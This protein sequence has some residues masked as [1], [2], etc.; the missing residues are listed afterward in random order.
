MTYIELLEGPVD[1]LRVDSQDVVVG[2]SGNGTLVESSNRAFRELHICC[3]K[4]I[5][6]VRVLTSLPDLPLAAEWN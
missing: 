3:N 1:A 4:T 5:L 6:Q 2:L